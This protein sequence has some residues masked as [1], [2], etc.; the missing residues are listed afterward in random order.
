MLTD[1]KKIKNK[2]IVLIIAGKNRMNIVT[3][4]QKDKITETAVR[5]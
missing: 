3:R 5:E 4:K 2:I 1:D